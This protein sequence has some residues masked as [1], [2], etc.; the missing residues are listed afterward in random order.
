MGLVLRATKTG[1]N[2]RMLSILTPEHGIISAM[3]KGSLRLKSK[4]FS[5]TGLF[6]YSEFT[7]F[8]R[9]NMY[10]VDDAEVREVFFGLHE[11]I[12]CM[13]VAMYLS[14]LASMLTPHG[15]ESD[16]QLRLLL[17]TFYF[18]SKK[19]RDTLLLKIIFE[20]RTMCNSGFMPDLVACNKCLCYN[21]DSFYFDNEN[22]VI[23]CE[24]CAKKRGLICNLDAAGINAMR[25]IAY[26]EDKMLFNFSLTQPSLAYTAQISENYTLSCIDRKPKSLEFLHSLL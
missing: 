1:E 24:N 8:A 22:S 9:K 20:L 25:H 13:A 15:E 19:K 26:S 16:V 14:E 7:L 2:D 6:C 23:I 12:T 18:L 10:I 11:D 4:L 3:A 17:N 21:A 5:S